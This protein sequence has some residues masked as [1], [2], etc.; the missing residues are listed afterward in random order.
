KLAS[1]YSPCNLLV[2]HR[3]LGRLR[4]TSRCLSGAAISPSETSR[5]ATPQR[6][7]ACLYRPRRYWLTSCGPFPHSTITLRDA[8]LP[9]SRPNIGAG[10]VQASHS[11]SITVVSPLLTSIVQLAA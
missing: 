1:C 7:G 11:A 8:P 10:S 5:T 4:L 2:K 3:N 9:C 6:L